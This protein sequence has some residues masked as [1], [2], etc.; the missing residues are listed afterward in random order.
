MS[1]LT[2]CLL[3]L[4]RTGLMAAFSRSSRRFLNYKDIRLLKQRRQNH[5]LNCSSDSWV[6]SGEDGFYTGTIV[7]KYYKE[8]F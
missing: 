2:L 4:S 1:L 8:G 6:R 5:H 7:S 3:L